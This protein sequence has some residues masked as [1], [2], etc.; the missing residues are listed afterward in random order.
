MPVWRKW[1]TRGSAA[2]GA[3]A[4]L[5]CAA[6]RR[7]AASA[8]VRLEELQRRQR[9][10]AG[11]RVAG[12]GVRVQEAARRAVVVEGGVDGVRRQHH[13]ERQRA[14]GDALRETEEVR[15]DL[16]LFVREEAARA[17]AADGDLV[18]DEVHAVVVAQAAGAAQV[19][20]VVHGHAGGALH[21]RLDD[22]RRDFGVVLGE[23]GFQ[24]DG[25][26]H[27]D[28]PCRLSFPGQA[29]VGA[30]HAVAG[31]QQR[32]VGVPEKRDV[33]HRQ[34]AE[35]LAVVAA[36]EAEEAVLAGMAR[37]AP[38]VETHLQ[39]NLHGRGAVGGVEAVAEFVVRSG[40][41]AS[42]RASPPA[43]G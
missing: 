37:V 30:G 28:V 26:R 24:R 2:S 19:F 16:C 35:R 29:P 43:R 3:A 8:S 36:G 23:G 9:G 12:V 1:R 4:A 32:R 11:E 27:G 22:E 25:G 38:E 34:R 42:P 5:I 7:L 18:G 20:G 13:R 6:S 14:A 31:A 15:H 17:A 39:G 41:R 10:A 33:G 40:R 21:Q